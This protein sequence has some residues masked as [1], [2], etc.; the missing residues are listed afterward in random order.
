MKK[1]I[2]SIFEA[3]PERLALVVCVLIMCSCTTQVSWIGTGT[4]YPPLPE[5]HPVDFFVERLSDRALWHG[6][7]PMAMKQT[8]PARDTKE[9]PKGA[10]KIGEMSTLTFYGS[11]AEKSEKLAAEA[12]RRGAHGVRL[13][14]MNIIKPTLIGWEFDA[15]RYPSE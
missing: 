11:D 4:T 10:F 5:N 15:L 9:V 13:E 2:F 12:R 1:Q 14:K 6:E 3:A 8:Y 7:T